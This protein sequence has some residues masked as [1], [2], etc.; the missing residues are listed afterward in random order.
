[1][2]NNFSTTN[3][4]EP[5][6]YN[7]S[8]FVLVRVGSWLIILFLIFCLF[9][10]NRTSDET[11]AN[12]QRTVLVR[13]YGASPAAV[14]QPG[15]IPLWFQ[16]TEDGPQLIAFIEDACFSRA[17]VPWPLA[18]HVRFLEEKDS[19]VFMAVNRDGF[20][21]FSHIAEKQAA[22]GKEKQEGVAMYRFTG[23]VF[24]QYTIG[25]FV[26]CDE[27]PVSLL[28]LDDRFLDSVSPPPLSRAWSFDM[29]SNTPFTVKIPA[30][31][32]Y[33]AE[34]GWEADTLRFGADGLFYYKV[35]NKSLSHASVHMMRTDNLAYTGKDVPIEVFYSFASGAEKPFHAGLPQLPEGFSYT[36]LGRVGD[37]LIASW[38]EQEDYSIGAAGFVVVKF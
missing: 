30:L 23:A 33:P 31:E 19:E 22:E 37:S 16:L 38:E 8:L 10:C 6:A 11:A 15:E 14:L 2:N 29:S 13:H 28:Y 4:H 21:K 34:E 5:L 32:H 7:E 25:G 27:I 24:R 17:L 20:L 18:L 12:G 35:F 36:A 1:M 9:S 26:F 3:A